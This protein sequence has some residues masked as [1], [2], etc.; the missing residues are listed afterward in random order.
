MVGCDWI[1]LPTCTL[2][3]NFTGN[4][5]VEVMKVKKAMGLVI[6]VV[7]GEKLFR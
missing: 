5:L 2:S 4:K 1:F 3:K 7:L 6:Y